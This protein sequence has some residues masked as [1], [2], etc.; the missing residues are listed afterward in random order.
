MKKL[1]FVA[2]LSS[3]FFTCNLFGDELTQSAKRGKKLYK[4]CIS[5]HGVKGEKNAKGQSKVISSWDKKTIFDALMGY[6][7]RTYGR[8]YKNTMRMFAMR[9]NKKKMEDI[10]EY[11]VHVNKSK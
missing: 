1:V 4:V 2:F 10:A 11:L 8:Q 5:C 3:L 7:K 9:L 6:K